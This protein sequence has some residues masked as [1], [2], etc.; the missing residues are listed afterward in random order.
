MTRQGSASERQLS[1]SRS[2]P[3]SGPAATATQQASPAA[4][5][6]RERTPDADTAA[7]PTSTTRSSAQHALHDCAPQAT[8]ASSYA[9]HAP[10]A[11]DLSPQQLPHQLA[12]PFA[13]P[14]V[15]DF[16]LPIYPLQVELRP[17]PRELDEQ[18]DSSRFGSS[19]RASAHSSPKE[20]VRQA[21]PGYTVAAQ[22]GGWPP[23]S[24]RRMPTPLLMY[25]GRAA[26]RDDALFEGSFFR[27]PVLEEALY[28]L[29]SESPRTA[30]YDAS[31]AGQP[32]QPWQT[33]CAPVE[34]DLCWDHSAC[35]PSS[36]NS[37]SR[38][39]AV[40]PRID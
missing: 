39:H 11:R 35:L 38:P 14:S 22:Q 30:R 37:S 10:R 20:E 31:A 34:R 24:P 25:P 1:R 12:E 13:E 19:A 40:L 36:G 16:P 32:R 2:P 7:V 5:C 9:P 17:Q 23:R 4:H 33:G 21:R 18:R 6:K 27:D 8:H 26:D 15:E 3:P 28:E 29:T